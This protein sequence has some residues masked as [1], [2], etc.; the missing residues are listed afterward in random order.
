M[1]RLR[2]SLLAG[3]ILL[4]CGLSAQSSSPFYTPEECPACAAWNAPRSPVQLFGNSY[5]VGTQGLGAILITSASG[6]VLIDGGLPE[7][8]P[9]ILENV[10]VL[11]FDPGDIKVILNSHAHYDHAGGMEELQRGTGAAVLATA[12]SAAVLRRGIPG[13]DDPQHESALPFPPVNEVGVVAPGDTVRVGHLNLVAHLTPG[14]SPGGTTWT[15][16][17]CDGAR[18]VA[19]AYA[20]SQTPV[21]DDAFRFSDGGRVAD[22][23]RGLATIADL[24]CEVLITPHPGASG[25]WERIEAREAGDLDALVDD[26]ACRRYA[27]RGREQLA[28]RLT[29]ERGPR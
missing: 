14:H 22:F 27:D 20:D 11:G 13:E 24:P 12:A 10:R 17:S 18:C 8:A 23:E 2:L 19:F 9:L 1:K 6:H 15:W 4:A 7:S 16:S 3:Q 5:W 29:R 21:S 28:R 25:L 26:D